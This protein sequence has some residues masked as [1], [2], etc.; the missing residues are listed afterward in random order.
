M[1]VLKF[2]IVNALGLKIPNAGRINARIFKVYNALVYWCLS[3]IT[4]K[5]TFVSRLIGTYSI[6]IRTAKRYQTPIVH[7]LV[8]G[9]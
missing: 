4:Q 3:V 6:I 2:N 9:L 1:F 7:Y 5:Y 8:H